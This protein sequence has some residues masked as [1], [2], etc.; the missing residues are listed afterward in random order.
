MQEGP[1]S[2]PGQMAGVSVSLNKYSIFTG[3]A[4]L[5]IKKKKNKLISHG[6]KKF[7]VFEAYLESHW[8]ET[9]MV[10]IS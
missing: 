2:F 3:S 5:E 8:K 6:K 1:G 7:P 9:A 10:V 4:F